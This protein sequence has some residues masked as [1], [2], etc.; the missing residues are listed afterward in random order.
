MRLSSP[1]LLALVAG[2]AVPG[3]LMGTVQA[4]ARA[5]GEAPAAIT[6]A[7]PASI[8]IAPSPVP[9]I[10]APRVA[11]DTI[12][13]RTDATPDIVG[14]PVTVSPLVMH[15]FVRADV[16]R[17]IQRLHRAAESSRGY[18]STAS[19]AQ[20]AWLLGLIYLHGAGVRRDPGLAQTWFDRAARLG[21]EPWAY[22][23]QAWCAIDG[24]QGPADPA[25]A[26]RAIAQ[27][28]S[29]HPARADFLERVLLARETPLQVSQPGVMQTETLRL[30]QP[31]LLRKAAAEGDMHALIELGLNAVTNNQLPEALTYFRR[32][33]GDSQAAQADIRQIES[34]LD[35][36][37][38][39]QS[40]TTSNSS[41]ADL[42]AAARRYHRGIGVPVNYVEAV[43]LY[44]QAEAKG[45][46]EAHKMLALIFSY[47]SPDGSIN[48]GWMQQLAYADPTTT[49]PSVG[50][51]GSID[52]LYRE[53]T[54]L[55]DLLP[56]FWRS[57][58]TLMTR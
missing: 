11:T 33:G 6:L 45:S 47:P 40:S 32:A 48:I 22:A 25:R 37:R 50:V 35:S 29:K 30:P 53:P 1:T 9:R 8:E 39:A 56:A 2:M 28:R 54:P 19:A 51:P 26:R 36:R 31:E 46:A 34:R 21:R 24:C 15:P 23:G 7:P 10:T 16:Q 41:A 52:L 17:E 49:I 12:E 20:A 58:V 38:S 44:R 4:E 55:Y 43:R 18:G 14:P 5:I 57:Q 42:L 27:L 3:W 13:P